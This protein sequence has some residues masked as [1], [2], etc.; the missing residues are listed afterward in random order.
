MEIQKLEMEPSR[1]H[2]LNPLNGDEIVEPPPNLA[3]RTCAKIWAT[4]DNEEQECTPNSG[5]FLDSAYFSPETFLPASY[6]LGASESEKPE[7]DVP[8]VPKNIKIDDEPPRQSSHWI[9]LVASVSVGM[10]IAIFLFPMI[11]F[12]KRSTRSYVAESW[13]TEIQNRVG[14]Y[15]QIHIIQ[16]GGTNGEELPPYNLAASGWQEWGAETFSLFTENDQR[17]YFAFAAQSIF[18]PTNHP[19]V[20]VYSSN[21]HIRIREWNALL[22]SDMSVLADSVLIVT[23]GQQISA[24]LAFGQNILLKDGRVFFR[25]LPGFETQKK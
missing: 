3:S 23:S 11:E 7:P 9:G 6:L 8:K 4:I 15:E 21:D 2:L 1:K 10:V 20:D 24:R 25:I 22:E 13:E 5:T 14:Q 18:D 17:T 12:V 19:P 16:N